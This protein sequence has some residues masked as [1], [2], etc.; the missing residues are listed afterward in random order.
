MTQQEVT[1]KDNTIAYQIYGRGAK[2]VICLHGYAQ[3]ASRWAIL[4]PYLQDQFT[5]YAIDLPYHGKTQWKHIDTFTVT[6]LV[7]IIQKI[8]PVSQKKFYLLAYSMGGRIGLRLLQEIPERIEK[9]I[10]LAPDGFH[11]NIWYRFATHTVIGRKIFN[12][13]KKNP[14]LII[15]IGKRLRKQGILSEQLYNLTHYYINDENARFLLYDRWISTRHF[16]PDLKILQQLIAS[17]NI[18]VEMVFARHDKIIVADHGITFMKGLEKQIRIHII[19]TGHSFLY[20][21]QAAYIASFFTEE[22]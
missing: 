6:A 4:E 17:Y 21:P 18:P 22:K 13:F 16:E 8:L 1:Y 11:R 19:D 12:E 10:L 14:K 7:E 20:A 9:A 3:V 15:A 5:L 2:A